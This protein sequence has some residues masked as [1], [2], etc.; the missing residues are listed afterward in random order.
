MKKLKTFW[1]N[2]GYIVSGGIILGVLAGVAIKYSYGLGYES[3][4]ENGE[5]YSTRRATDA[6]DFLQTNHHFKAIDCSSGEEVDLIEFIRT[7]YSY[8]FK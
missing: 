7:K 5:I 6:L 2:Y 8:M 3:G 1:D 4:F